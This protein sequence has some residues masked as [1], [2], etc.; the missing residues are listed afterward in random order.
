MPG[1]FELYKYKV[2]DIVTLKKAHPCGSYDWVVERT[3]QDIS[4]RCA[5][6]GHFMVISRRKLEKATKS[7]RIKGDMV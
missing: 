2:N 6:C 1:R 7:V 5:K 4:I 3:G